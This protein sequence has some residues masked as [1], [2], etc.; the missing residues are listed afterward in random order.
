[1]GRTFAQLDET[2][3]TWINQQP[4]MF[5]AT[6]PSDLDGH[7]NISPKGDA[8]TF[9]VLGSTQ[10]AYLDLVGSGVETIAHIREN[11]RIVVMF[12]AFDGPPKVLRL[13]GRGRVIQANDPDFE[14][15]VAQFAP[16][17]ELL[18]ILRSVILVDITRV[19]DS[20]GFVV[21]KMEFVE[22]RDQLVRW[23]E[24]QSE[25]HGDGWKERYFQANNLA[26]IDGLDGLDPA[27]LAN[28]IA[29]ADAAKLSSE[30]K[31]L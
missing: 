8:R 13:H 12:C 26:S 15:M 19:G 18:A 23:S 31:A 5:V 9:R 6:A 3:T 22:Q 24:H 17:V 1:M 28:P 30:G 10:F 20:C 25:R 2:L 7:V 4:M 21:P 27:A 29:M 16:P 14:R 11:G